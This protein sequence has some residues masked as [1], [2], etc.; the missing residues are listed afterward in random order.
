MGTNIPTTT[1]IK[2]L[3]MRVDSVSGDT[4]R[5]M[6]FDVAAQKLYRFD[7]KKKEADVWDMAAFAKQTSTVDAS[8]MTASIRPTGQSKQIAGRT[9]DSYEMSISVPMVVGDPK[10]GM[11]M[12][13]NLTGPVWIATGAPGTEDYL[14]F[15]KAAAEKGFIFGDPS[16]AKG[17]AGQMKAMTEMYR[18]LAQ[19]GGVPYEVEMNIRLGGDGPMAGLM[20]RMG[21]IASTTVVQSADT[22]PL[23]EEL[24][25]PPAGYKLNAR[26]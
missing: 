11:K 22:A 23:A 2:G 16:A 19:T 20:A 6:I 13:A 21:G 24:F 14:Q 5:T 15:Y 7:N 12:M 9:A 1:Y 17:A 10:D 3:R 26:Q 8:Q 4:T 25:A 18:Q